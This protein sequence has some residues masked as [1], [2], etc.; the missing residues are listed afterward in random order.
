MRV[1]KL[2]FNQVSFHQRIVTRF[3]NDMWA[4]SCANVR[5]ADRRS[6]ELVV[7]STKNHCSQNAIA[8]NSPFR[9][10]H[11]RNVDEVEF[12]ERVGKGVVF[13]VKTTG[14]ARRD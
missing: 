8:P 12:S 13:F 5:N 14:V 1:A 9:R 3:P 2:S 4:S 10:R 7:S 6:G 11:S